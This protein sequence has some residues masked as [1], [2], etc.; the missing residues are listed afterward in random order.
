MLSFNRKRKG[1]RNK[2]HKRLAVFGVMV[3]IILSFTTGALLYY[4]YGEK[5]GTENINTA[6]NR[7]EP[8]TNTLKPVDNQADPSENDDKI[9]EN[10]DK[11]ATEV[12][13]PQETE[14]PTNTDEQKDDTRKNTVPSAPEDGSLKEYEI[15]FEDIFKKDGVKNAFLTFDDGPTRKITPQIL[16]ILKSYNIKASFFVLGER[17]DSNPD[18][19]KR[20]YEEGHAICLHSYSHD[21]EKLY[22]SKEFFIQDLDA[23]VTSVKNVLGKDFSTRIYRFPGGSS[24]DKKKSYRELL[25][26]AGYYFIDWNALNGDAEL[27]KKNGKSTTRNAEELVVRLKESMV[28]TG[29]P[30]D[31][32]VLMHDATTKQATADALPEI[33]KYLQAQGYNF[34]TMR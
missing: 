7:V 34:K 13:K 16:D 33:I 1:Y 8:E 2:K 6:G 28:E 5:S 18:L 4:K 26:E 19:L 32:V 22:N 23:V 15:K 14:T 24:G 17:V 11:P 12:D 27:I 20:A 30:E 25:K 29:N 9:V 3:G 21:Y 31:I 10:T